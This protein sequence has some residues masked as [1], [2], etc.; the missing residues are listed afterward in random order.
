MSDLVKD[1][2]CGMQVDPRQLVT[3]Y[4]ESSYAFCS[5]QC[6]ERF[7]ENPHLYIGLPG[8]K[9]A[10]QKGMEVLKQ[11]RL[12]LAQVLNLSIAENLIEVLQKMMG[13]KSV[14][15]EGSR[16]EITY[17]LLQVTAEQIEVV[18]VELGV[19]FGG[20]WAERLRR[21]FVHYEEELEIGS[22]EVR[23]EKHLHH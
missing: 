4:R 6:Q 2:V 14:V 8:Q 15:V 11:R 23:K 17:D 13:I 12:Q 9:A 21:A 22:L 19:Q 20:E 1:P 16:I 5:S 18:I 10:K 7:L 3:E